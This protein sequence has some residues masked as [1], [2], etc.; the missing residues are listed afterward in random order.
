MG[1]PQRLETVSLVC[2]M[3][4]GAEEQN[5]IR[6][7]DISWQRTGIADGRAGKWSLR[8][9]LGGLLCQLHM[10]RSDVDQVQLIALCG[11][12][13]GMT[14][15]PSTDIQDR[16]WRWREES[17]EK[18]TRALTLKLTAAGMQS[19]RFVSGGVVLSDLSGP[20]RK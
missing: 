2:Q 6:C 17:R 20:R 11:Q 16:G 13:A 18:L 4:E 10:Q 5:S 19:I 7:L 14:A 15:R 1:F 8:L 3:I 9:T 12:P